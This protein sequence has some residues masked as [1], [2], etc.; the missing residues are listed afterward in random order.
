MAFKKEIA[1]IIEPKNVFVGNKNALVTLVE[2]GEYE[3]DDCAKANE[4]VKRLLEEY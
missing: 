4:V 3:N 2:F 1:E